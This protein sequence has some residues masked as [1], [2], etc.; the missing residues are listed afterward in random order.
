MGSVALTLR[1]TCHVLDHS[2][3]IVALR[4]DIVA[5][6]VN[7]ALYQIVIVAFVFFRYSMGR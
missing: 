1:T 2:L 4:L 7:I 3:V 6:Q 5:A